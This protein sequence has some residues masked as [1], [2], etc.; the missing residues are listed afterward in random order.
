MSSHEVDLTESHEL[1]R[2]A[3]FRPAPHTS[4]SLMDGRSILFS[5]KNQKIYELNKTGALIWCKLLDHTSLESIYRELVEFGIERQDASS[6]VRQ[7]LRQW[8]DLGLVEMEWK[9]ESGPALQTHLAQRI[10]RIGA[11]NE[12]LVKRLESLFCVFGHG[13]DQTDIAIEILQL[14]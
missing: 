3:G 1:A 10:V 11:T 5:E 12:E 9:P 6:S 8:L 2:R 14:D 4:F 7:A 13:N